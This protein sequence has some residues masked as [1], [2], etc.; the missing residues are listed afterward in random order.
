MRV[1]TDSEIFGV[2]ACL[3][4]PYRAVSSRKPC[5]HLTFRDDAGYMSSAQMN[6]DG[7]KPLAYRSNRP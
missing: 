3:A 1:N 5:R 4:W 6:Q 2:H 7:L